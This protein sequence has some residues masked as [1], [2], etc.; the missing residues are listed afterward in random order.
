M[1][2]A[3]LRCSLRWSTVVDSVQLPMLTLKILCWLSQ[4]Q[5]NCQTMAPTTDRNFPTGHTQTVLSTAPEAPLPLW[6]LPSWWGL[7]WEKAAGRLSMNSSAGGSWAATD[8]LGKVR[9][10]PYTISAE[11]RLLSSLGAALSLKRIQGR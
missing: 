5:K 7:K 1:G 11:E 9:V 8:C 4:Q 10:V 6:K 2:K 3:A